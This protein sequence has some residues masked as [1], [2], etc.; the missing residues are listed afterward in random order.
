[1]PQLRRQGPRS[2]GSLPPQTSA[3]SHNTRP[4]HG[5]TFPE[6]YVSNV[7]RFGPGLSAH[8]SSEMPVWGPSLPGISRITMKPPCGSASEFVRLPRIDS[9]E[10][11][12]RA[13][14]E[15]CPTPRMEISRCDI[16]GITK[17]GRRLSLCSLQPSRQAAGFRG[18]SLLIYSSLRSKR[19]FGTH[20]QQSR[21]IRRASTRRRSSVLR[22]TRVP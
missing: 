18:N 20:K 14:G 15:K 13:L 6:E 2:C 1:M 8:G 4:E 7:L 3:Q 12:G 22:T 5:G 19:M 11:T 17:C 16:A 10:M 21:R 9:G